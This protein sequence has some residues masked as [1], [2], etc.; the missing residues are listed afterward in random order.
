MKLTVNEI[1]MLIEALDLYV[2]KCIDRE[3]EF[4]DK[5]NTSGA[6]M[7]G[8]F[9]QEATALIDKLQNTPLS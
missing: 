8:R 7:W 1:N 9:N 4:L 2:D 5:D 3:T 6:E